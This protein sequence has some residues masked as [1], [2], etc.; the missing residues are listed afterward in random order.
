MESKTK[1]L[2]CYL[3][4]G[5]RNA[6]AKRAGVHRNTL[7]NALKRT[8][9]MEMSHAEFVAYSAFVEF[10]EEKKRVINKVKYL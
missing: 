5:D 1:E 2:L 10:V 6:I 9:V 4:A 7:A 3:S 8:D